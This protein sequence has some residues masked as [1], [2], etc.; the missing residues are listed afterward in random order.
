MI[1]LLLLVLCACSRGDASSSLYRSEET[2]KS[3]ELTEEELN[4]VT[5]LS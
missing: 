4:K 3:R 1:L 2:P 5:A